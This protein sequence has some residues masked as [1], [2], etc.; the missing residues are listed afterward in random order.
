MAVYREPFGAKEK[1][2]LFLRWGAAQRKMGDGGRGGLGA[3]GAATIHAA[4]SR[5]AP[6][7]TSEPNKNKRTAET[8]KDW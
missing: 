2:G 5:D 1:C 4:T 3:G 6:E 8:S 7:R